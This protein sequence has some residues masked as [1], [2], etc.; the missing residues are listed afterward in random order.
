M[1]YPQSFDKTNIMG[2][3]SAA[4]TAYPSGASDFTP[5]FFFRFVL[6]NTLVFCVVF[7]RSL[8]VFLSR[9]GHDRMVVGFTTTCA[10][11]AYHH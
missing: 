4:E 1:T 7:C 11:S 9:R 3:T 8:F 6:L 2:V 10:I 5:V